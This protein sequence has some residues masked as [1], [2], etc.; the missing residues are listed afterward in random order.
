MR[1]AFLFGAF[2]LM[3]SVNG[4]RAMQNEPTEFRGMEWGAPI[5]KYTGELT[6]LSGD[7]VQ[8]HYR[9]AADPSAYAQI[10][11][12]RIS[13]RF[14][15][16]QFS[17]GMLVLV[18]TT[19]LKAMLEHLTRRYGEPDTANS[20]H[21]IYAWEGERAGIVLSCDIS[22]SCYVE[23]FGRELRKLELAEQGTPADK[24]DTD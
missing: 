11:V 16:G 1:I 6:V 9:R 17:A 14:Y 22:I 5:E 21:R 3:L 20:R 23:F 2:A 4:A 24:L 19:N 10:D 18:G 8:A 12:R 13:Y 7:G 15:K